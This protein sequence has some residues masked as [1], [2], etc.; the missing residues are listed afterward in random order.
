MNNS[1]KVGQY[2]KLP[3]NKIFKRY[4]EGGLRLKKKY[5]NSKQPLITIITVTKNSERF[6]ETTIKSVINQ[7]NKNFEYILIDGGSTDST[8]NIIKKYQNR[9]NYWV[10]ED[11]KGIYSAFNKGLSLAQGEYIGFVNSDDKLKKKALSILGKY[12]KQYPDLDFFFGTVKKHWGVLHGY[13]PWKIFYSWGFYTSHS[14]GFYIKKKSAKK[15]GYYNLKYKYSSDFDYLYRMIVKFK[16]KGMAVKKNELFG[17][18]RRGG[19]SSKVRFIDHVKEDYKI[20][21]NNGQNII[22]ILLIFFY[23]IIKNI[24]KII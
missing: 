12:I 20:R 2:Y 14:T 4:S 22:L 5:N 8:L 18:F 21:S 24:K 11:D 15:I 13:K 3:L 23:K 9:I 19:F 7:T 1:H 16:M 6:L 10:S 17:I